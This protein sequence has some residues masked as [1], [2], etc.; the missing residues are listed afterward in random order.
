MYPN[1]SKGAITM[2]STVTNATEYRNLPLALLTESKTNPR[3]TFEDDSLKE[4]AES[5][6]TQGILSPLLVRPI[7]EQG[8]EIVF[9]ARRYRA[10]QMAEA[11]TVP[12]RI[13]NLTDAEALEAQLIENLQRRDV[14]PMEEAN[15]FRALL[16]LEEPKYSI[17]QIAARTGKSPAYVAGRLK[18]TELAPVVVEAFYREEIGVGHA[19]LLA[20]L[21]PDQQEQALGACFKE[22]WSN[23]GQKAKRILLPVRSLQFW[24]E[25]NILLILKLAPFDKR[26]VQLVPAAGSCVDCPKRTGH[27]KLLF[28]DV[29]QDACTDPNCYHANVDAHVAKTVAAKPKLVQISTAYGQ[30]QEGSATLPR[31]KYTEIR[32]E[33]PT[34]KEEAVRPE[35]KTCKYTTEA[36]VS[37]GID[38]GEIR[39]VCTEANCPVHHP[40]KRPQQIADDAKWKAEQE[41][42]RREAAIANTTGIRILAAITAAVP[43]RLIKRDLLFVVERLASL[44]DENRLAVVA[45][46]HGIKKAKDSDS[47]GKLFVAYLRRADE[48]A[49]G[50]LL[51]EITI[52]HAATRQNAAEV[53]RDAAT[54]YKVDVDAIGLKV[55]QEFAAKEKARLT[56]K[57]PTKAVAKA[58]PTKKAKAA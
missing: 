36:I 52:L 31:N 54:A 49:L 37:D 27:N 6:R 7:T 30:Q 2:N 11:A 45:R 22:D 4:L 44:L 51:V 15:G 34:T 48:S 43:V 47:I 21:Q 33:K 26:D 16:N 9:G 41:K 13:K 35:F 58:Q 19:L 50:G 42:Q 39:K 53:L 46:Q 1:R 56:S 20:K 29:R 12:V 18:L 25:S 28:A 10:A 57:P 5:I 55:K 40:K 23:V 8:F 38:K 32:P 24:I 17:E 14:H 3:R